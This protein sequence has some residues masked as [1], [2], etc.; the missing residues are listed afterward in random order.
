M[1]WPTRWGREADGLAAGGLGLRDA[2]M[3]ER[4]AIFAKIALRARRRNS[5]N[6]AKR[7]DRQGPEGPHRVVVRV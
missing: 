3:A 5:A 4:F 2:D 6:Y 1:W 7:F